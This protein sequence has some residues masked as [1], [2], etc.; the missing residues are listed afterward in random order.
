MDTA[1]RHARES[2]RVAGAESRREPARAL[3]P[4]ALTP[5]ALARLL[6]VAACL[7]VAAASARAQVVG[8]VKT[9][10]EIPIFEEAIKQL[11]ASCGA[12][13]AV[14]SLSADRTR[15]PKVQEKL[16]KQSPVVWVPVGPLA[17]EQVAKASLTAPVI[18]M[19]DPKPEKSLP[20]GARNVA[21]VT[22]R[23]EVEPQL[24]ELRKNLP[25]AKKVGVLYDTKNSEAEVASA[26][27]ASAGLDLEIVPATMTDASGLA[28]ALSGLLAKKID[29]LWMV[30]DST[31]TPP[32]N[33]EAFQ[34]IY[35]NTI[36]AGVPVVGYTDRLT[37]AGAVFSLQPDYAEIGVQAGEMVKK[38]AGGVSPESLG[39]Q[40]A[41]KA[42]LSVNL[43]VA[44]TLGITLPAEAVSRAVLKVQ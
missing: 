11:E 37:Q 42:V 26:T 1:S 2:A 21:G 4:R 30:P 16:G 14:D 3:T 7:A 22:M 15:W 12:R 8:V 39:I 29:V 43:K 32:G 33:Q 27:K 13:L 41:R 38:V 31:V 6:A 19:M 10:D 28:A 36:K 18:F 17:L 5:R 24:R 34:Y 25:S 40:R 44:G 20:P 23:L 35:A 9:A